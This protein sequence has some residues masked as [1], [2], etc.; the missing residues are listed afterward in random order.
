MKAQNQGSIV[1]I[2]S[3]SSLKGFS[4]GSAYASSKFALR[5]FT[6]SLAEEVRQFNIRVFQVNPS[7]VSTALGNPERIER[8]ENDF[9]LGPEQIAHTI[10]SILQLPQKAFVPEV[11]V[12][13][14]NP[15]F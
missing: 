9:K 7:E 5:G 13:A 6:Q 1:N 10:V 12:W 11:S 4:N 3:T 15:K 14:T 8:K 2:A